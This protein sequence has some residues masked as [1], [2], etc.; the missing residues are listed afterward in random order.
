MKTT[1]R[2]GMFETNSSSMQ[3]LV[4]C[5]KDDFD[6]WEKDQMVLCAPLEKLISMSERSSRV[7]PEDYWTYQ[8]FAESYMP[9]EYVRSYTSK[10]GDEIVAFGYDS[11]WG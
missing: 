3:S 7:P 9:S 6:K 11:F 10:N 2:D 8:E 5:P 1:I 4:V